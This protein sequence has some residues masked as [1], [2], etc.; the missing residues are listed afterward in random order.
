MN[1]LYNLKLTLS[2]LIQIES[3]I[4][5]RK[6]WFEKLSKNTYDKEIKE[7]YKSEIEDIERL[8]TKINIY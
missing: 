2:E 5:F 3:I 8:L 1:K 7:M 4:R 6:L